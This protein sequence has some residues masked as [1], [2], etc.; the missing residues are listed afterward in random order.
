MR[1]GFTLIELT[2]VLF[3]IGIFLSLSVPNIGNFLF[4][5]DLKSTA[6]SLKA[7]VHV[8]RSKSIAT[9]RHA[10]LCF[11]L[12]KMTYWGELE[13]EEARLFTDGD[14]D[15]ERIISERSLPDGIRIMDAMNIRVDKIESGELRS[16]LN[17]K[18]VIEE[19]VLHLADRSGRVLTIII[20]AY[21]GRF[22]LYDTY[23]DVEY[24][25]HVSE[26]PAG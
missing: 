15:N 4:H 2:V 22:S 3:L 20:N 17:P 14:R 8:L 9:G 19:T 13:P 24:G 21:T 16:I 11:D 1:R 18:G 7:A 12:D 26:G 6:R 25:T 23:R 5:S 10:V